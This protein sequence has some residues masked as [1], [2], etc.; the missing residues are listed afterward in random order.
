MLL[1][2]DLEE[3][4]TNTNNI[5]RDLAKKSQGFCISMKAPISYNNV[6]AL[7]RAGSAWFV[8]RNLQVVYRRSIGMKSPA[9]TSL[10]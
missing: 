2:L 6:F 1:R 8:G 3:I 10:R 9:N 4:Y 7:R 5:K